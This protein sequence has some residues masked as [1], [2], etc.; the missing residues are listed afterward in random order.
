MQNSYYRFTKKR[1]EHKGY[2]PSFSKSSKIWTQCWKENKQAK[3]IRFTW[4]MILLHGKVKL[5]M[6]N[7]LVITSTESVTNTAH[8]SLSE[9]YHHWT[10]YGR[11]CRFSPEKQQKAKS[12]AQSKFIWSAI[13]WNHWQRVLLYVPT[14]SGQAG[15]THS[16]MLNTEYP[17]TLWHR[18]FISLSN[19]PPISLGGREIGHLIFFSSI[20]YSNI[21]PKNWPANKT[22][23]RRARPSQQTF[24][25]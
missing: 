1:W 7:N 15:R 20:F 19:H 16:W 22:S 6:T 24:W 2:L 4:L 21:L 8:P 9:A 12:M 13:M 17:N 18:Q 25:A 10:F 14:A 3:L 5:I 23:S 11:C